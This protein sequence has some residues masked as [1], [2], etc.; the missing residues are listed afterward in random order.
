MSATLPAPSPAPLPSA[1]PDRA[2]VDLERRAA[3]VASAAIGGAG[4]AAAAVPFIASWGP[5]EREK[6]A[7]SPVDVD[8]SS[9]LPGKM[10]I[11]EWRGKPIWIL[12]R[13]PAMIE[14]LRT[15]A[16]RLADP[17]SKRSAFP[18]PAYALKDPAT[19]SIRPDLLVVVGI[20][21]HLG[22]SPSGPFAAEEDAQLGAD[23]GFVCPCHGSTF[24]LA[25]RV[26][27][28][29]PAADNLAV[30]PHRYLTDSMIRIGEDTQ[31]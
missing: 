12:R 7:G 14:T 9:L 29:K 6:A 26:F 15:D 3:I 16:A 24:D 2:G 8:V 17:D 5:S 19:R 27:R 23:P 1:A 28:N 30:P 31:V 18:T 10:L 13:T 11:A 21:T 22:C 4:V 20:C 25:G